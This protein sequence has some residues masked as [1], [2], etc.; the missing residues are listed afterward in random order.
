[1]STVSLSPGTPYV[2]GAWDKGGGERVTVIFNPATE[3]PIGE[4]HESSVDD[5]NRAVAAARRAFDDGRG[6]W[7][8]MSPKERSAVLHR[9]ADAVAARRDDLMFILENEIGCAGMAGKVSHVEEAIR[10]AYFWADRAAELKFDEP[11]PPTAGLTGMGQALVRR[12]PDR[13]SVV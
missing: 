4:V 5:V 8:K 3:Q 12:E 2:N 11:L 6:A 9:F 7:P 13:K 10:L 1:M